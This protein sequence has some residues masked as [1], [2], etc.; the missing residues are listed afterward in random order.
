MPSTRARL[1]PCSPAGDAV[2]HIRSS[3]CAAGKPGTLSSTRQITCAARS[4]GRTSTSDPFCARPIGDRPNATMTASVTLFSPL[5]KGSDDRCRQLEL[6]VVRI[7]ELQNVDAERRQSSDLTMPH[8]A[9]VEQPHRLLELGPTT[10]A[11]AQ[12]IEPHPILVEAIA[13][14]RHRPQT[15][16]QVAADHDASAKENRACCRR[17]RI[18]VR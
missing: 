8:A 10:H 16:Q 2:P 7:A 15:H 12:V 4:S 13:A 5:Q 9:L 17:V 3:I 11:E 14:R 1:W 18:V 6:N